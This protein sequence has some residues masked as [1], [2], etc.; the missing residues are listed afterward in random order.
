MHRAGYKMVAS[1]SEELVPQVSKIL[2]FIDT[3]CTMVA[4]L[5]SG[6]PAVPLRPRISRSLA[7]GVRCQYS[8]FLVLRDAAA[9]RRYTGVDLQPSSSSRSMALELPPQPTFEV[10]NASPADYRDLARDPSVLQAVRTMPLKLVAPVN[11]SEALAAAAATASPGPTWGV[12]AVGADMSAFSGKNVKV[13][14]QGSG[15]ITV[16]AEKP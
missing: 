12:K 5:T 2:R 3:C 6:R 16:F 8:K 11:Q 10:V 15:R 9:K 7:V 4:V 13:G 14:T 1:Q